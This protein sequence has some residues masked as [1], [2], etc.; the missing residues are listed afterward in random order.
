M[1]TPLQSGPIPGYIR[2]I[3][4]TMKARGETLRPGDV[5]MHNDPYGGAS[6]GPDV[7]FCVPVFLDEKLI[8]F[9]VTTCRP[10]AAQLSLARKLADNVKQHVAP[11]HGARDLRDPREVLRLRRRDQRPVAVGQGLVLPLPHQLRRALAA[12]VADLRA[13][14]GAAVGVH[15][16]DDALPRSLMLRRIHSRAAYCDQMRNGGWRKIGKFTK[17][18]FNGPYTNWQCLFLIYLHS[19]GDRGKTFRFLAIGEE[20]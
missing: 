7:A 16:V 14:A 3:L 9:S 4:K 19:F 5:V 6:H 15:E 1:S 2:G 13:D 12:G 18:I 8:G 17:A 11:G 20:R 10:A